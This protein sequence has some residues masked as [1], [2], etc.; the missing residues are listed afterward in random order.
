MR[1]GAQRPS[2]DVTRLPQLVAI[3]LSW[4][5]KEKKHNCN[6]AQRKKSFAVLIDSDLLRCLEAG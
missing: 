4:Q 6:V 2:L 5:L 3:V 1:H